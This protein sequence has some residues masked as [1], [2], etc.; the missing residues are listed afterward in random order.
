M[1]K[2]TEDALAPL[3]VKTFAELWEL[4][5]SEI[6]PKLD[7]VSLHVGDAFIAVLVL[8][9]VGELRAV[10][11]ATDA[12]TRQLVCAAR[13]TLGVAVVALAATIVIAIATAK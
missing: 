3:G 8:K 13:L 5:L 2:W 6:M 1:S 7:E 9:A 12:K 4:P 10:T 11:L